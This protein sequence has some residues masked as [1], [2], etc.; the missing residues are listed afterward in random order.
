MSNNQSDIQVQMIWPE[1]LL[2]SPPSVRLPSGYRLRTYQ[3]GDETRFYKLMELAGWLGWDD[4]KLKPWLFRILP[5]GWFM[6]VHEE[7]DEIVATSMA[8]HDHTWHTPFCGEVGWTATHPAHTGKGLGT[9][10]ISAVT[11]RFLEAGYK[12]IHLYTEIWRLAALKIYLK[13][14]YIPLIDSS[15]D[16]GLW[17]DIYEQLDMPFSQESQ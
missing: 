17:Q 5:D 3:P 14:G 6:A 13:L 12:N 2:D 10:V 8:T 15:E 4:K 1:H 11:I 9:V 7:S 16:E